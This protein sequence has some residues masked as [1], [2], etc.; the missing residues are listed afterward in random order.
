MQRLLLQ[1][2][3]RARELEMGHQSLLSK[4]RQMEADHAAAQEAARLMEELS[5]QHAEEEARK[6]EETR[7]AEEERL[8]CGLRH[9][10]L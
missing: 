9:K 6:L 5:R 8:R 10:I 3:K 1:V 2:K 4:Q 7:Q